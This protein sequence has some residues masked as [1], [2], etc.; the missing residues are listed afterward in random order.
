MLQ[1]WQG[2]WGPWWRTTA[3]RTWP[4]L[5]SSEYG[6][7]GNEGPCLFSSQFLFLYE[8]P[9]YPTFPLVISWRKTNPGV[10]WG[11]DWATWL[12]KQPS[13][14]SLAPCHYRRYYFDPC[15]PTHCLLKCILI[16]PPEK[17][18]LKHWLLPLRT[19]PPLY[20]LVT[21]DNILCDTNISLIY[22][23]GNWRPIV[24]VERPCVWETL[25]KSEKKTFFTNWDNLAYFNIY[26][27]F[28]CYFFF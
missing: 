23:W 9:R 28:T 17:K 14:G 22:I 5:L 15:E 6:N 3:A 25:S 1:S 20:I 21:V 11:C 19:A 4:T 7:Q 13:E 10:L 8:D 16:Y 12:C 26:C 24:F 2:I 27:F 18:N